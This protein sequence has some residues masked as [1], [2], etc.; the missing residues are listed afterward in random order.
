MNEIQVGQVGWSSDPFALEQHY[1]DG[2]T[3]WI[4]IVEATKYD[5]AQIIKDAQWTGK[6]VELPILQLRRWG[7]WT[8]EERP[9]VFLLGKY[10]LR[11]VDRNPVALAV[12]C[13]RDNWIWWIVPLQS[14]LRRQSVLFYWRTLLTLQ[15]WNMVAGV[16]T[17]K[18]FGE[19]RLR[20]FPAWHKKHKSDAS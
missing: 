10:R 1:P 13:V 16:N 5:R 8:S 19:Q 14:W 17:E 11:V 9:E 2:M 6:I 18:S 15:I 12:I 4:T 3:V 7:I 20:W